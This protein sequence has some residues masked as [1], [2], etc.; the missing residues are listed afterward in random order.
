VIPQEWRPGHAAAALPLTNP[1]IS[2]TQL[3]LRTIA[4]DCLLVRTRGRCPL[5]RN[6]DVVPAAAEFRIG[7]VLQLGRQ[8]LFLVGG[9]GG[10]DLGAPATYPDFPFGEA[11][12]FGIVG[13]SSI[14][15]QLRAQIAAIAQKSGHVLVHG[16]SGTGKELVVRALHALSERGRRPLVARSAT[17]LPDAL[18]DAELFGN[19]KNYPNSGMPE[20]IGLVGEAD[21]SCLFLD[22][23]GELPVASQA[24]LLR[25]LDQ[26]EYHR[27]G[28]ARSRRS[29]F[30]LL[31][32]T[33]RDPAAALKHD[34]GAR[35]TFRILVPRLDERREDIPLIIR[36]M[37]RRS[38]APGEPD[39]E[40]NVMRNL[41]QRSYPL[42]VRELEARLWQDPASASGSLD[43]AVQA[44]SSQLASFQAAPAALTAER[45]QQCLDENNGSLQA[46]FKAL[47]MKN[48][49]VLLRMIKRHGLEVRRKP[50][51]A[52][53]PPG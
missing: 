40:L 48:R 12:P 20:R 11:D 24:H 31:V 27:L 26:G 10:P 53:R 32:A 17:T 14:A 36:H 23:I 3:E 43:S 50:G 29:N 45:I 42:N 6:G 49:F 46:T 18:I 52:T 30:R 51:R 4:S 1:A 47:G 5:L 8:L 19:Q 25:V 37:V 35:L 38:A 28:E 39:I 7:D 15:W 33:N 2:R 9:R 13:E 22:E 34:L 41:V 16:P 44:S 21:G